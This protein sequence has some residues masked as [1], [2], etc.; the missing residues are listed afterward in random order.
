MLLSDI[1]LLR[2]HQARIKPVVVPAA[3]AASSDSAHREKRI[4]ALSCLRLRVI[5]QK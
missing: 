4:A 3:K 2:I 1:V 5:A